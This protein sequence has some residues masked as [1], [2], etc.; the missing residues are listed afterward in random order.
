MPRLPA[1]DWGIFFVSAQGVV[2]IDYRSV[3]PAQ[4]A[5]TGGRGG[6]FGPQGPSF[7]GGRKFVLYLKADSD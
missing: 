3:G 5:K 4:G 2:G 1:R 7:A 6:L